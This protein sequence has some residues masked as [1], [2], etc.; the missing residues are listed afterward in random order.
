MDMLKHKT[1]RLVE[2]ASAIDPA[3]NSI[4]IT[5]ITDNIIKMF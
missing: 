3:E 2:S 4:S 5:H 1:A